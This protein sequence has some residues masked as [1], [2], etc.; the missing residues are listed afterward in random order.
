MIHLLLIAALAQ[1]GSPATEEARSLVDGVAR[2]GDEQTVNRTSPWWQDV[3]DPGLHAILERG[4]SQN[5]DLLSA[6]ARVVLAK[7][8]T[9]QSLGALLPTIALEYS[10]QE[11]PTDGMGLSPFTASMPNYT[12]AFASLGEMLAGVGAAT[13]MDPA[14]VP[15]FSGGETAE[16]PDTYTQS[17]AM[18]KGSWLI[19]VFG[20]QTMTTM[21]AGK[22]ARAT[23]EG[24]AATMRS[25]S[26]QLG[27][28]WYDLV[29][30]RE[31]LRI[32]KEQVD[33]A[34]EMLE[35]VELRYARGEG[36]ALD[37]LQQRQQLASTQ[38]ML[39]RAR[40]GLVAAH[41]MVA[42][43]L[44]EAPSFELPQSS[45]WP[46]VGDSL[47]IGLPSRLIDDRADIRS[48][49]H[50]LES[51]QLQRGAAIA[52]LAPTLTLTGQYGRQY[53]TMTETEDV[54][55][56]AVGALAS[57]PLF[58]GGRTHAGIKAA[59]AGRDIAQ[60]QLRATILGAVQQVETAIAQETAARETLDAVYIQADAAEKA[61]KESRTHYLQGLT[62]Y[63]TV[64][65]SHAA[66][67]AA[68]LAL[69]DAQRGR[70]QARIQLHSAL[71]GT[72]MSSGE[73]NQ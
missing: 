5:L 2:Y 62:P 65:A 46:D 73:T 45:G 3:D 34:Q 20:K 64:L 71:G 23:N 49:I 68:Q 13:G 11:A 54:D 58:G 6:D 53:L 7:A 18:V 26:A 47:A 4:L 24:R 44:G 50:Q 19:D 37:V 43:G 29:A 59:R 14:D 42:I 72:W 66:N 22:E 70:I 36:S 67:Q 8:R 63:V 28:A 40:A 41:G 15:D 32:V 31:Q 51:A 57:M 30:A 52:G 39:P 27:S 10:T 35:L 9:W 16:P 56:W 61:W 48:A 21:A 55:N 1:A 25:L 17:S 33:A 69:V 60:M 38:A 12:E